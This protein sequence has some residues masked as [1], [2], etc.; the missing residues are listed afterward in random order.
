MVA[1]TKSIPMTDQKIL[2]AEP[3]FFW[4]EVYSDVQF[5]LQVI[6]H[7]HIMV[8][9]E[10]VDR[11]SGITYLRE[12]AQQADMPFRNNFTV[13]IPEIEHIS[14]QEYVGR[15]V[16]N[17]FKKSDNDLFPLKARYGVG[18]AKVQVTADLDF[19]R[20]KTTS[21]SFSEPGTAPVVNESTSNETYTGDSAAGVSAASPASTNTAMPQLPS[22]K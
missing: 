20:R 1:G 15:V 4:F 17:G 9:N 6:L 22:K 5:F 10:E 3:E 18:R 11:N 2:V 7:P 12:L 21:E 19:D 16:L 8:A 13:F 14:H